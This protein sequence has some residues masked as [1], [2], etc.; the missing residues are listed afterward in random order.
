MFRFKLSGRDFLVAAFVFLSAIGV[1]RV[2]AQDDPPGRIGRIA[3]VQG[4]VWIFDTER[5]EWAATS[6][7]QPL[8]TGD[9]I[10]V[11]A[12][13]RAVVRIGSTSVRLAGGSE[14]EMQRLDDDRITLFLHNGSVGVRVTAAEVVDEV[15]LATPEGR[16][17][18]RR[19]GHFRLDRNDGITQATAW[20]GELQLI[21]SDSGLTLVK[22]QRVELRQEAGVSRARL[23]LLASVRDAFSDWVA[24][25]VEEESRRATPSYVSPEMT[26]WED[27]DRHGRWDTDPEYGAIWTPSAVAVGWEPYR[28][29]RWIWVKPWGWTW[30]DDAPWGFAPFHYG[31]WVTISGRWVW[32]PGQRVQRPVYAPALVSW[33]NGHNGSS[34]SFSFGVRTSPPA[35]WAPLPPRETYRPHYRSSSEH[36]HRI[37]LPHQRESSRDDRPRGEYPRFE[38]PRRDETPHRTEPRN[39]PRN[40]P[41]KESPRPES[42]SKPHGS[43][44][45]SPPVRAAE[46]V[47]P[48]SLNRA[49]LLPAPAIPVAPPVVREPD[50]ARGGNRGREWTTDSVMPRRV[51]P[52]TGQSSPSELHIRRQAPVPYSPPV[53]RPVET[54]APAPVQQGRGSHGDKDGRE[55]ERDDRG[56]GKDGRKYSRE[57]ER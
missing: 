17:V 2:N 20:N 48:P 11:A 18:P 47:T 29:G 23:T 53:A 40:E 50:R 12:D 14:L 25:D 41:R 16:F 21:G 44:Y 8:T 22:G 26:G 32:S 27:L 55:A 10:A 15:E 33:S 42:E 36:E 13:G 37:N 31:R 19:T 5:W 45:S 30:M 1:T 39:E 28:N 43:S 9:R 24:K 54:P 3:D 56:K 49:P 51:E 7:N 6:R 34:V 4:Q 57:A 52:V 46:P 35:R 38:S